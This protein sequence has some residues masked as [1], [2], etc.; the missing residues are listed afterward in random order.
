M[1]D[2]TIRPRR[3][4]GATACGIWCGRRGCPR[5]P[6]LPH[7]CG[8]AAH[9]QA[10]HRRAGGSVPLRAGQRLRCGA[11]VRGGRG[12]PVHPS[13][14]CR[15]RRTPAAPPPGT[16][17]AWS[18]RPSGPSRRKFPTSTS[19]PTCVCA[20]TP[21][22]ATGESL[23]GQRW[24]TTRPWSLS[25]TALSHVGGRGGHGG[26]SDM[27]DGRVAAIRAVLDKN[28]HQNTP[29]HVLLRQVRQRVLRPLPG[30]GGL[31]ALLRGPEGATRWTPTTAREAVKECALDVGGGGRTSSW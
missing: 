3:L 10:P 12:G 1:M 14:A 19:S 7:L 11:G 18:S 23:R 27:M 25:R 9:R 2:M 4:R 6:H 31:R 13:S 15:Q 30:G 20:S 8:R 24:T 16:G 5:Q 29:H 28:G 26:P 21:T 22:T 17:R